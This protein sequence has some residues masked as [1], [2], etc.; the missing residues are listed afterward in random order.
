MT[1]PVAQSAVQAL[2]ARVCTAC[3]MLCDDLTPG[4][5]VPQN[6]CE[7][8]RKAFAA[9]L[10]AHGAPGA[11]AWIAGS[12]SGLPAALDRAVDCLR[13]A[14][15]VLVT[16]LAAAT[17][18]GVAAACDIAELL[19]AAVDSGHPDGFRATG[20]TIARAGEVTASWDE[21]QDR[22]DLVIF[23]FCDPSRSHP[24]FLERHLPRKRHC[25]TISVGPDEIAPSIPGCRRIRISQAAAPEAAR[26]VHAMLAGH[27][28][29]DRE[30]LI[31]AC[32]EIAAAIHGAVCVAIVTVLDDPVGIDAWSIVH[33]VR[34][35]AHERPAFQI[36]LGA[37]IAAAGPNA[38]G[39]AAIST[40]RYGAAAAVARADRSGGRFRPAESDALRL[41]ERREVD[42]VL[43]LGPLP[44]PIDAALAES[45]IAAVRL[46][47]EGAIPAQFQT[48]AAV[49]I[50]CRPAQFGEGGTM[51]REDG[52][53]VLL[54]PFSAASGR[55]GRAAVLQRLGHLLTTRLEPAAGGGK[56]P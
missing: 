17:M 54:E 23:W 29:P 30:P 5:D 6:A 44:A 27:G 25:R 32:R 24:R 36:P 40:W 51:L 18:E 15:R 33:L 11:E 53:T 34:T 10:A 56:S 1:P 16:G 7:T 55:P 22:A 50:A 8:G 37:G 9:G 21:F 19:A 47:D 43:T 49:Q 12:P 39:A 48:A 20:P 31:A 4:T 35:I 42:C 52:R 28:L 41:I 46:V 26:V 2:P 38:S 45:G 13:S 3:P 14:R